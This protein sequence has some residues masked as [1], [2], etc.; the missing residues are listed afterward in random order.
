MENSKANLCYPPKLRVSKYVYRT[1]IVWTLISGK[2]RETEWT[3]LPNM[4]VVAKQN[5]KRY[6]PGDHTKKMKM[7]GY[8]GL[9]PHTE[10]TSSRMS[11]SAVSSAS[12]SGAVMLTNSNQSYCL[13]RPKIVNIVSSC[14]AE[15]MKPLK[16]LENI[17]FRTLIQVLNPRAVISF[18]LFQ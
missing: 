15:D 14:I 17:R 6:H 16:I 9:T 13:M 12:V 8:V 11:L 18:V 3:S 10:R 7:R 2:G 1:S 4:A 5:P